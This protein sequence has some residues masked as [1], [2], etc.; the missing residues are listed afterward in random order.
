MAILPESPLAHHRPGGGFRNPWPGIEP[1]GL[2]DLLRWQMDRIHGTP[3]DPPRSSFERATPDFPV[4][5]AAEME[6]LATWVGHSTVLLQL[7]TTNV[8]TDPIWSARASPLSFIGPK[9]WVDPGVELGRLPPLDLVLLS[10]NHYDHLDER[11]VR[12]LASLHP[13]AAWV[14]PLGLALRL[15]SWGV[16][17]VSELD[18]WESLRVSEATITCTPAQHFSAR[19][20][21]DRNRTL[22]CGYAVHTRSHR[23]FFAGDTGYHPD[24]GRIG[25]RLGPFDLALIPIGAYAPRWFMRSVHMDADEALSAYNDVRAAHPVSRPAML[26]IHW[27]TFKLTDEP[28]DE[29]P[30]RLRDAWQRAALDT[31]RLWLLKHGETRRR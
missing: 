18:W 22:W 12:R 23:V 2:G 1:H 8:L 24:F 29:P 21:G 30:R 4:P 31:G 13:A 16:R 17:K 3:Q 25:A 28:M 27:G 26:P 11:T 14:V 10:H 6:L 5:R 15:R 9:R 7:G 19:G 20:F